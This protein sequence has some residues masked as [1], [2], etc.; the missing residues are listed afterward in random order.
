MAASIL[1]DMA[2]LPEAPA[3]AAETGLVARLV[4]VCERAGQVQCLLI[5]DHQLKVSS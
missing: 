5:T 3:H 2:L 1:L 4:Q